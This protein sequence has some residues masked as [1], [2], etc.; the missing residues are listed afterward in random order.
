MVIKEGYE[1]D[2]LVL[3]DIFVNYKDNIKF[4]IN[5]LFDVFN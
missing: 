3:I 2:G 4:L 1:I 5:M